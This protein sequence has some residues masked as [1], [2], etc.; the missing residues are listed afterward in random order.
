MYDARNTAL[1]SCFRNR[2]GGLNV[3]RIEALRSA[4]VQHRHQVHNCVSTFERGVDRFRK[5]HIRLNE[6]HL[7][8]IAQHAKC[9]SEMRPSHG[10]THARATF[11][12]RTYNMCADEAGTA[13]NNN[14]L[15]AHELLRQRRFRSD[16]P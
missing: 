9:V 7:A 4:L 10:H 6:L 15:I 13:E 12:K 14:K 16:A 3:Q 5:P 2:A 11:R 1:G 8:H